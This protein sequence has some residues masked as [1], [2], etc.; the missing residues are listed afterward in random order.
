[1]EMLLHEEFDDSKFSHRFKKLNNAMAKLV[2][3]LV[4]CASLHHTFLF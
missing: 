4:V 1:M 3:F 2:N